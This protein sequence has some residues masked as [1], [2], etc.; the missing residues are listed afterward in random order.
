MN[1][2]IS[3]VKDAIDNNNS[4]FLYSW[5]KLFTNLKKKKKIQTNTTIKPLKEKLEK[6]LYGEK[7]N[8]REPILASVFIS[9]KTSS[10]YKLCSK[11]LL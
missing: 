1:Y 10:S 8:I 9:N 4:V 11:L 7:K 3:S 2:L 6:N 5:I